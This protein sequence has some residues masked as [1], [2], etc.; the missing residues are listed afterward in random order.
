MSDDAKAK[1]E[2]QAAKRGVESKTPEQ[3][4]A[5]T[6]V[7][8]T[9]PDLADKGGAYLEDCQISDAVADHALDPAD[10]A[11]LWTL[12]EELTGEPFPT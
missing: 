8:A 11:R 3:G 4:A 9:S 7:A 10:A 5:T 6:V 2:R 12:S 1:L